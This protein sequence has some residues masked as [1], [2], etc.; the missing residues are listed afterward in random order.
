MV[1][2]MDNKTHWCGEGQK[3]SAQENVNLHSQVKKWAF[4]S[5]WAGLILFPPF[6]FNSYDPIF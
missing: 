4:R 6:Q 1:A 5:Q 3:K 2:A